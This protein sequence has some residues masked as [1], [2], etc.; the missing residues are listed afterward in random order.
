MLL[1]SVT[2]NVLENKVIK[3]SSLS[4]LA[5]LLYVIDNNIRYSYI[6]NLWLLNNSIMDP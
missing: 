6:Y 5:L 3:L 2:Y 1:K 4:Y